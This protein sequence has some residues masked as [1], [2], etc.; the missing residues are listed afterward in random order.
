[1]SIKNTSFSPSFIEGYAAIYNYADSQ[2]D[3]ILPGAF[4]NI[5]IQ[6]I[7]ILWQHEHNSPIGCISHIKDDRHG[8][9]IKAVITEDTALGREVIALTKQ[10]IVNGLSIG[11]ECC[12]AYY[13]A[14]NIRYLEQV[15]LLEISIVT[16]PANEFAI[17]QTS[18][19]SRII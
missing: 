9:Y 3:I 17:I 2:G 8:L 15:N 14:N 16:F 11:Y 4:G 10:Q 1:M 18:A 5:D 19:P 6:K 7:K 12:K 13:D